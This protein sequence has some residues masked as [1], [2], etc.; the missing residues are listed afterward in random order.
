MSNERYAY[1]PLWEGDCERVPPEDPD[2]FLYVD[3]D[4]PDECDECKYMDAYPNCGKETCEYYRQQ[5]GL[6]E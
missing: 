1:N 3:Q 6:D 2:W 4:R 5:N